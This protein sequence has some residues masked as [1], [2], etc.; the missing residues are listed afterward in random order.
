MHH[1]LAVAITVLAQQQ[2]PPSWAPAID[3]MMQR[4]MA[5]THTPGA[6]ISVVQNGRVVYTKG[7]GVADVE[8]GRPVTD[9]TLF[10]TGSVPKLF[11]GLLLA[12]LANNGTLDLH[13]PAS[14][15]LPEIAGRKVGE[16][17][18]HDLLTH[19]AGW[20]NS[21]NA[22]GPLDENAFDVAHRNIADTMIVPG[23][24]GIYSYSNPSLAMAGYIAERAARR[25]FAV[26]QDSLLLRPL[27]MMRST[28]RPMVAMTYDFSLGH[29]RAP[30]AA[31]STVVRP[32]PANAAH[33][34]SGFVYTNTAETARLAIAMMNDG[35]IDGRRVLSPDAIR[36]VTTAHVMRGGSRVL[37]VGYGMNSDSIF[38]HRFWQKGG[39]VDGYR[40]LL[41][42][43]PSE[44]LAIVV[45]VNQQSDL[46]Y[47]VT[48]QA[49]Q[50]IAGIA[51]PRLPADP[52][53]TAGR[54][55]TAAER[56][57]LIGTYRL[58]RRTFTIEELDG[59]LV[60]RVANPF[61]ITMT[62][63]DRFIVIT[64][65]NGDVTE[66]QVVRDGDGKVHYLFTGQ[67]A[68]PRVKP[69]DR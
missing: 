13:A 34:G 55:P 30:G 25:P 19:S 49:A 66:F 52:P 62:G 8:T 57:E 53:P 21:G 27:G 58:G 11:T 10:Q 7:Y 3:S 31:V 29:V 36:A 68:F 60:R 5:R 4:E 1:F 9:R 50:L 17:T 65:A 63:K 32:M 37:G 61:P 48:S 43:W 14:R 42:M 23:L 38:K 6:Q 69:G 18:A 44:N 12:Q 67:A 26:V 47:L 22:W 59:R 41:T 54:E 45:F 40:A 28:M 56:A 51:H 2:N 64:S 16:T 20:I 15:Y 46:T 24:R 33:W 35:M 39:S